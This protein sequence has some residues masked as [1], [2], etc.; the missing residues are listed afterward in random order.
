MPADNQTIDLRIG[1]ARDLRDI[2]TSLYDLHNLNITMKASDWEYQSYG[3]Q[4]LVKFLEE[5]HSAPIVITNGANQG[6]HAAMY[7]LQKKGFKNL[8]FRIPY[9]SRIPEIAKSVGLGYTPFEGDL[10]SEKKLDI[11]SY[12]LTMPNNPDGHLPPLDVVRMVSALLKQQR[13]PLIHDAVYY[14]R[15][16]L[17]IDR[18]IESLGD[19]QLYSA[20]KTYGL[21]ALRVGYMIVHNTEFYDSLNDY[22][23][24]ST[25]GVSV[26][27]Q[28]L[29]LHILNREEQL[30][31]LK[32]NFD[33]M[34][35]EALKKSKTIFKT[36][37]SENIELPDNFDRCCGMFAWVK[38]KKQDLFKK[39]NIEVID[40]NA[41]GKPEYVRINLAAGSAIIAEAVRRINNVS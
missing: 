38:P 7:A 31:F 10:L 32:T 23:E 16:Y 9:W 18:P 12:L 30:P 27:A 37:S 17:P 33:T 41:F 4:P 22:M 39:A 14:T 6:L 29:F 2:T 20:S 34:T 28:K 24:L 8:G 3:Y 40:G 36:V 11:D 19:L 26:P 25:V 1:E 35:R 5:K 21:S 15:S 13:I